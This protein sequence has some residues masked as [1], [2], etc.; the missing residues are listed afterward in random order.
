MFDV[1]ML[2][3][4]PV[5]KIKYEKHEEIKDKIFKFMNSN[6]ELEIDGITSPELKHF[7]NSSEI[8]E[9]FF[10]YVNDYDFKNFLINSASVFSEEVMGF[11]RQ[12]MII[13]DCWLNNCYSGGFQNYHNHVNSFISGTYYINYDSKIH[14][15]LKFSNPLFGC[16]NSPYIDLNTNKETEFNQRETICNFIEE[17]FLI[18]WMSHLNHGYYINTNNGRITLSM[19]FMPA[20]LKSGPYKFK[21][22]K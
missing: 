10:D 20:I 2:F 17:G 15:I 22:E 14:S 6:S 9:E 16:V 5:A 19:N 1:H 12:Q 11:E 4:T 13:T 18:L 7:F 8:E 21:I 3:P